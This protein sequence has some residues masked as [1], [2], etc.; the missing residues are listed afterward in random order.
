MKIQLIGKVATLL[1]SVGPKLKTWIY[2]DGKF[3][4]TRSVI[5][6]AASVLIGLGYYLMPHE[7]EHIITTLD[8]VSDILGYSE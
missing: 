7:M 5:L 4:K 6:L 1:T 8:Q 2:S 3:N